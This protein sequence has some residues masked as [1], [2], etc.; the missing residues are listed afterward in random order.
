MT[1]F[2]KATPT[3]AS[4]MTFANASHLLVTTENIACEPVHYKLPSIDSDN[5]AQAGMGSPILAKPL[6]A[7]CLQRSIRR[8]S[9]LLN[10]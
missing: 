4:T 8:T 2:D 9:R 10:V 6:E 7:Q 3:S 1:S 5:E